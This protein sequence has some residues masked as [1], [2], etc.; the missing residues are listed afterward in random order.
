MTMFDS[1]VTLA[2]Q[3]VREVR[4]Y[5]TDAVYNSVIPRTI[6]LGE[7]PSFGKTITEYDTNGRGA[8]GYRQLAQEFLKRRGVAATAPAHA[9]V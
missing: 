6:R 1:R 9:A 7:A 2:N 5:F 4:Q 3:V 8:I